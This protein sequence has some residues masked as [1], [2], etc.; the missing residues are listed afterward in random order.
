MDVLM[1]ALSKTDKAN[2][3]E[4]KS[5]NISTSQKL[6][7][8]KCFEMEMKRKETGWNFMQK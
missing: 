3:I 7:A 8:V 6:K 5:N 1:S 4:L 2:A